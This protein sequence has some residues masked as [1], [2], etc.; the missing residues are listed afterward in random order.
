MMPGID[1][2]RLWVFDFDGT[3]SSLVPDRTVARLHPAS[4]ALIKDLAAE[5]RDRVA[6][7]SSRTLEDIVPRVPVPQAYLG[8]GSGLEWRI[9]GGCRISPGYEAEKKLEEV[10]RDFLPKLER[11]GAFPGV[12]LEDKRWSVSV[13]YRHVPP[14]TLSAL[15]AL[16]DEMKREP[17]LR[18][19]EGPAVA[20]VQLFPS[21]DKSF[22]IRRLCHLLSFRPS[23]GR[24]FYAGDD[25]NDAVAMRW[26]LARK[27]TVFAVGGRV[28]VEGARYV[29]GPVDLAQAVRELCRMPAAKPGSTLTRHLRD[30]LTLFLT[31]RSGR[32]E[33]ILYV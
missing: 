5:P 24:I 7:L 23:D 18:L 8:G 11:I 32:N 4:L 22:G 9:P 30:Y 27:G 29:D 13:H 15:F 16:L 31:I 20:E 17:A 14:D 3:L 6:V 12:E 10:R 21:V 1:I 2:R 25:E 33:R 28:R 19:F 26:V